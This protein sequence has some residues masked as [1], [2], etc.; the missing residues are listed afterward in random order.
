MASGAEWAVPGGQVGSISA[1]GPNEN[2][3]NVLMVL[4]PWHLEAP[5]RVTVEKNPPENNDIRR[6]H[7]ILVGGLL[8]SAGHLAGGGRSADDDGGG[9]D[10]V[11]YV[12]AP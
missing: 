8:D 9:H 1:T 6:L 10:V 4:Q 2:V 11:D 3:R 5:V 7:A 12:E